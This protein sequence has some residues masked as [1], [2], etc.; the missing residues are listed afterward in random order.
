M[1]SPAL[2]ACLALA[3]HV[4]RVIDGLSYPHSDS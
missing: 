1:G 4:R 3:D 2:T